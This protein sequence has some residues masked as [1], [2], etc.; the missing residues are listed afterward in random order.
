MANSEDDNKPNWEIRLY[1]SIEEAFDFFNQRLFGGQL[2][3]PLLTL[4]RKSGTA[5]YYSRRRFK[6]IGG[7][8]YVDEIA[9][10]PNHFVARGEVENMQTLVHEMCHMWQENF[11]LK[12]PRRNYHNKEFAEKMKGAGLM[13]SADGKIGGMETGQTM[14]DYPIPGG[15]FEIAFKVWEAQGEPIRWAS[16]EA[17]LEANQPINPTGE[18]N[19]EI[20]M[21]VRTKT[22]KKGKLKFSCPVCKQNAWAK[23]TASLNCGVCN[24][25]ML[26]QDV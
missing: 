20:K 9:L 7:D 8:R 11:G 10:N 6:E 22:Q 17:F 13:P 2:P 12:K 25:P 23:E 4:Q 15:V 21:V 19:G 1:S 3:R 5:G 24:L 18:P 16:L 26:L 14:S